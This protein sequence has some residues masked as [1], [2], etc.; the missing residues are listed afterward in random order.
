MTHWPAHT[1]SEVVDFLRSRH[2]SEQG[3]VRAASER[4]GVSPQAVSAVFRRDDANL[5]WAEG[6]AVAYGYRLRLVYPEYEFNGVSMSDRVAR[7]DYPGAG[8]LAGLVRYAKSQNLTINALAQRAGV[9]YRIIDRAFGKGDIKISTLKSVCRK[10]GI[11][12][13]WKWE[14]VPPLTGKSR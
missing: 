3:V 9:N 5:S 14:P 1:L 7:G 6:L 13:S 12:F 2:P 8:N 10:L 11:E 4:L